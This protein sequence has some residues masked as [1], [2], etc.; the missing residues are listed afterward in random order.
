MKLTV[1][2]TFLGWGIMIAAFAPFPYNAVFQFSFTYYG[3]L[4][5]IEYFY[6]GKK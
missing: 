3:T 5:L 2:L 4:T 1:G 6:G